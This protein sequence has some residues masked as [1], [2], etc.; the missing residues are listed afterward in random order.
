ME[1]QEERQPHRGGLSRG[2]KAGCRP[3]ER[4]QSRCRC[5]RRAA[6]GAT[7]DT[8]IT[9]VRG[10]GLRPEKTFLGLDLAA[11]RDVVLF[12]VVET[13]AREIIER[14]RDAGRFD[15]EPGTGIAFKCR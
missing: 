1:P 12:L 15:S 3:R 5:G 7:G 13:R 9:N 2:I 4:R 6:A 14:I 8:I 10:G 11:K